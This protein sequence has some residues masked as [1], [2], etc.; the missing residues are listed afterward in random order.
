MVAAILGI[1]G[2]LS[3]TRI[4]AFGAMAGLKRPLE[5]STSPFQAAV[6]VLVDLTI[7]A[8]VAPFP[9]FGLWPRRLLFLGALAARRIAGAAWG[10]STRKAR[11]EAAAASP[12]ISG[13]RRATAES[14]ARRS[15]RSGRPGSEPAA[16]AGWATGTCSAWARSDGRA[17]CAR[18]SKT[19][20]TRTAGRRRAG[21]ARRSGRARAHPSRLGLRL[22]DDDGATLHQAARELFDRRLGTVV[23]RGLD[24]R[25]ATR[26][27]RVSVQ[28]DPNAAY[29]YPFTGEG[30]TQLLL[31]DVV[32]K[33][34]DKK[35][36]THTSL[37]LRADR[38]LTF[39]D[40]DDR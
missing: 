3:T 28:R 36:S 30:L 35:T 34:P 13:T 7:P 19:A 29:F 9:L 22:L 12:S 10:C 33:I 38:L 11:I 8:P 1:Q 4:R 2:S 15:A 37:F 23:G 26:P 16:R 14:G 18:R 32:R 21:N 40:W 6:S 25:E 17:G 20:T 24:E 31:V 39:V 5:Q 27:T